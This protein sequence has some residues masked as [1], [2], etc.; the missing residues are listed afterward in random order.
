MSVGWVV[1]QGRNVIRRIYEGLYLEYKILTTCTPRQYIHFG[2]WSI[3]TF[4]ADLRHLLAGS[5]RGLSGHT[6]FKLPFF[7]LCITNHWSRF[8]G[9]NLPSVGSFQHTMAMKLEAPPT[10]L[11]DILA[12][13]KTLAF[14]RFNVED[15]WELGTAIRNN[16]RELP[17]NPSPS[18]TLR[19][20]RA[21]ACFG[22][23]LQPALCQVP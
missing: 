15:A 6:E 20:A 1:A 2:H 11:Q 17:G 18:S 8:T 4:L 21:L 10:A 3:F 5:G 19:S 16:L 7:H 23:S 12:V 22:P 13:E 14:P 9:I